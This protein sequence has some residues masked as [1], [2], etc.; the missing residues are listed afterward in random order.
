MLKAIQPKPVFCDLDPVGIIFYVPAEYIFHGFVRLMNDL[1]ILHI[2]PHA[3]AA[4]AQI[5]MKTEAA[6]FS[7]YIWYN[8]LKRGKLQSTVRGVARKVSV[9]QII[10]TAKER[11]PGAM[12]YA[13]AMMIQYNNKNKYRL[14][15]RM[16][17]GGKNVVYEDENEDEGL[18]D[19]P[20]N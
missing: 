2:N 11:R 19:N 9:K 8:V 18:T 4:P 20:G 16:L 12:G 15:L 17:Y 3:G 13:E 5:G 7:V 14:S 10:R 6:E 1:H